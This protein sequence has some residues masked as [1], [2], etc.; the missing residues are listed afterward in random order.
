MT[1][2]GY[3][4]LFSLQCTLGGVSSQDLSVIPLPEA[5]QAMRDHA[6][7]FRPGPAGG[8]VAGQYA[9]DDNSNAF[10]IRPLAGV[11]RFPFLLRLRDPHFLQ[12]ADLQNAGQDTERVGRRMYYFTNLDDDNKIDGNTNNHQLNLSHDTN[13]SPADMWSVISASFGFTVDAAKYTEVQLY[14][15]LAGQP[16]KK[17]PS[18][19]TAG[20]PQAQFI[21]NGYQPG[22]YRLQWTGAAD[23]TEHVYAG[24]AAAEADFFALVE[25]YKDAEANSDLLQDKGTT[26]TIA[27]KQAA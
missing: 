2:T 14:E 11:T 19:Y 18:I 21:L 15:V 22:A 27:F 8:F 24:D 16:D 26:Y 9:I 25:I 23:R 3:H 7:T 6:M 13:V 12:H 20:Q 5:L 17:L 4:I 1:E 10:L